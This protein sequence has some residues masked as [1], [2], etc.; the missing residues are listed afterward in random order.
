L[1]HLISMT[2]I[3]QG[4]PMEGDICRVKNY[5]T[6]NHNDD[7]SRE[8]NGLA[9]NPPPPYPT[10]ASHLH[11]L[12]RRRLTFRPLCLFVR[13][14]ICFF[15]WLL[16]CLSAP[17]CRASHPIASPHHVVALHLVS[18][19]PS[20][21]VVIES[22]CRCIS[23]RLVPPLSSQDVDIDALVAHLP[24][25]ARCLLGDVYE[26]ICFGLVTVK[27]CINFRLVTC[28]RTILKFGKK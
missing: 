9:E 3:R 16:R 27:E 15:G 8:R 13:P 14:F 2:V 19:R 21:L 17:C 24:L 7:V 12:P 25:M 18:C 6:N 23:S 20:H 22:S 28:H 5:T 10:L 1:A 26:C 4:V 11:L